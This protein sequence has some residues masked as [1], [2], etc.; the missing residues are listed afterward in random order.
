MKAMLAVTFFVFAAATATS[1]LPTSPT[2]KSL[3]SRR[4]LMEGETWTKYR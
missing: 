2:R 3:H 4:M 1:R